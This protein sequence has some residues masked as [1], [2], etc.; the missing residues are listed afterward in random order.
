MNVFKY[1]MPRQYLLR[2][3]LRYLRFLVRACKNARQRIVK[4]Y[5][6][7]D[8]S[9]IDNWLLTVLPCMFKDLAEKPAY[10][11]Y[12]PFD[13]EE[14]WKAWLNS[15]AEKL[16]SYQEDWAET[17]N[18]YDR[19]YMDRLDKCIDKSRH[20]PA[21]WSFDYSKDPGLL[22]LRAKWDARYQELYKEQ[23][24]SQAQ[25]F[26]EIGENLKALWW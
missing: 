12:E 11:G 9:D 20:G 3:P 24:K 21:A 5:C 23:Q 13:T 2:H 26:C 25:T 6:D 15:T 4:G 17:R 18:E 22:A 16:I 14:K 10:P 1:D 19:E 8:V 7:H